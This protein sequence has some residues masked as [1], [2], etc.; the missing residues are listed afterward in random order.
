VGLKEAGTLLDREVFDIQQGAY[1]PVAGIEL[2]STASTPPE[3]VG[4]WPEQRGDGLAAGQY[5][6]HTGAT[7]TLPYLPDPL[8]VGVTLEDPVT[9]AVYQR[10]FAGNWPEVEP[11][12]LV[13]R[14]G[15]EVDVEPRVE[16][17]GGTVDVFLPKAAIYKLRYSCHAD[18]SGLATMAWFQ[19]LQGEALSRSRAGTHWMLTPQREMTLVH[20][21]QQPLQDPVAEVEKDADRATGQTFATLRGQVLCHGASTGRVDVLAHW[22]DP[23]DLVTDPGPSKVGQRAHIAEFTPAYG[24]D[25]LPLSAGTYRHE[26]GDTKHR[27]VV[28]QAIGTTRF[29]EYFPVEV[30]KDKARITSAEQVAAPGTLGD[31]EPQFTKVAVSVLS[32]TRPD[33]PKV[34]YAVPTF[35]W[36]TSGGGKRRTR[37]GNGVRVY[38][39][40]P[41]Y[42]SGDGELLAATVAPAGA[43]ANTIERFVSEWGSDPI[44]RNPAP[45]NRLGLGH[46]RGSKRTGKGLT[47][48]DGPSVV[49]DVAG[50]EP[51]YHAERQLWFCDIQLD[52]GDAYMPFV[53]LALARYQPESLPG[54]ELSRLVRAEF[55]QLAPDRSVVVSR[56]APG[57]VS[58]ALSG[59][60]GDNEDGEP[61]V[62][63][64]GSPQD[65]ASPPAPSDGFDLAAP[66]LAPDPSKAQHHMVRARLELK[67]GST[68]LDWRPLDQGV[69]LPA[70]HKGS[71]PG[72]V[73][74]RG[75]LPLPQ[76]AQQSPGSWRIAVLEYEVL[77][78][79]PDVAQ[80]GPTVKKI[81]SHVA[82]R[83]VFAGHLD[84]PS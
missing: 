38:L 61:Q 2:V 53:R 43:N 84:I 24:Q 17:E 58:V 79:D 60:T 68:D 16:V 25:T 72:T 36:D 52:A 30:W 74:W 42:S 18:P 57:T 78:T 8:V 28:Y 77:P 27:N 33:A 1:V 14:E 13:V 49:V 64:V 66:D 12:R 26:L 46:F 31:N 75:N 50:F 73:V 41:W 62:P 82:S 71:A 32:T 39:D 4:K 48:A 20:A 63:E 35:L 44:R 70:Y 7:L 37:R 59:V 21:V 22:V 5:V 15:S 51:Q 76:A 29:R 56:T 54:L 55:L 80:T 19:G 47:L 83:I 40:R 65:I 10:S 23:V 34:L 67:L 69:E 81:A 9:G 11:F 3:R 6:M 45:Q